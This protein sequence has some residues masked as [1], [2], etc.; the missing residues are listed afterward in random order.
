MLPH[1]YELPAALLLVLSGA[2]ACFAG[3]RLFRLVLA[4]FGFLFGAW[5]ASSMMGVTNTMGMLAAA[6]VGGLAGALILV[7]AYFVGIALVGA[8]LGALVAH[9]SWAQF[10]ATDPPAVIVV[11]LAVLG[12]VGAMMLQRYVIIVGTAFGGAW[13]LLVGALALTSDRPPARGA[14]PGGDVWVLYPLTPAPGQRWLPVAWLALS[15]V[16]MAVQLGVTGKKPQ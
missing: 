15:I 11:L 13:T 8:G 6:I 14:T 16:G 1:S 10:G 4:I 12:A 5:L 7:F 3:Y 9:V 2:I